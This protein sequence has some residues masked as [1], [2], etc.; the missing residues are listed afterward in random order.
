MNIYDVIKSDKFYVLDTETTGLGHTA[1]ICQIAVIDSSG[2]VLMNT[3]VKPVNPM[4]YGAMDVHGITDEMVAGAPTWD[5]VSY[6]LEA[7]ISG[8]NVI[9]YNAVFDRKMMEQSSE[10]AYLPKVEWK[11]IAK[12]HCAMLAFAE[13]YGDWNKFLQSYRWQK[14]ATAAKYYNIP[15][16]DAHHALI[17]CLT[18]LAVCKAM[19][20]GK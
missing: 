4:G 10:Q 7:I 17:D 14:L 9:I 2:G 16:S 12:F 6:V 18:T 13:I 5:A 15:V 11:N 19:A 3:L 20:K 8:Q 1:E